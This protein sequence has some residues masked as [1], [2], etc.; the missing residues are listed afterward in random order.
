[1]RERIGLQLFLIGSII[2]MNWD[3]TIIIAIIS[4]NQ[5]MLLLYLSDFSWSKRGMGGG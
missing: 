1:M 4:W 5:M 2:H 3:G